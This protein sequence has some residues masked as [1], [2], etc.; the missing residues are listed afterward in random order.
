MAHKNQQRE[1]AVIGLGRFGS[2]LARR[3]EEFGHSVL[4]IDSDPQRTKEIADEITETAII[5]A[6]NPNAL[7]EVDITAFS[8]VIVAIEADF[9][10]SALITSSLKDL[11]VPQ[12]ICRSASRR[13]RD[14]LLRIGADRVIMPTEE[15]GLQLA[16]ELSTPGMLDRMS[17]SPEY[18]LIEMR[19]PAGLVS[20]RVELSEKYAVQLLLIIRGD[21]LI[22][23]P[24]SGLQIAEGDI[25]VLVGDKNRLAEFSSIR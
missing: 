4:G 18:S 2:S 19:A 6:T 3:L 1:F 12:V 22:I 20:R 5:D 25:L 10:A 23:S 14:I 15:A 16:D 21:E 13:H 7:Q 9:E 17:L 24:E 8:T 11:G